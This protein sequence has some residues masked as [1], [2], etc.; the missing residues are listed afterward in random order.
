MLSYLEADLGVVGFPYIP[1]Y[2]SEEFSLKIFRGGSS[3]S[4]HSLWMFAWGRIEGLKES[5]ALFS[6]KL[7]STSLL[8]FFSGLLSILLSLLAESR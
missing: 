2:R 8:K 5:F 7:S 4:S 3:T 6:F 1:M